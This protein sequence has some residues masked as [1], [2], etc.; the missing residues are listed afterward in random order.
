LELPFKILLRCESLSP[1]A[2]AHRCKVIPERIV[3]NA[4]LIC[5]IKVTYIKLNIKH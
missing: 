5:P 4:K 3:V 1:E 2:A